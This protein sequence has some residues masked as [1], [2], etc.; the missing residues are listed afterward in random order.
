MTENC[1]EEKLENYGPCEKNIRV[2]FGLNSNLLYYEV[3]GFSIKSAVRAGI[4]PY[5][6]LL[7]KC[8]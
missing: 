5:L 4:I 1:D 7:Q 6:H 3:D 2:N 8:R